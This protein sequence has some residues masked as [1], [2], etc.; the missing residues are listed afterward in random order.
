MS[1]TKCNFEIGL[2]A[3]D[4][5]VSSCMKQSFFFFR[6]AN[7]LTSL[8]DF[9]SPPHSNAYAGLGLCCSLAAYCHFHMFGSW[10]GGEGDWGGG[11]GA[12]GF[13]IL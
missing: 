10:C 2:Q 13:E 4:S 9:P 8:V 3:L 12:S 11:D 7:S 1:E 6:N 5:T